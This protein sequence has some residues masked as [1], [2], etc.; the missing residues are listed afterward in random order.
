[1]YAYQRFFNLLHIEMWHIVVISI[2]CNHLFCVQLLKPRHVCDQRVQVLQDEIWI[3]AKGQD[4][5]R[6][7]TDWWW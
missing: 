1:M 7:L 6:T 3:G 4:A 2:L 5:D